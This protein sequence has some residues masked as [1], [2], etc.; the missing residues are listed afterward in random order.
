MPA[1]PGGE[2]LDELIMAMGPTRLEAKRAAVD[3]STAP[4]VDHALVRAYVFGELPRDEANRVKDLI[5]KYEIWE[6]AKRAPLREYGPTLARLLDEPIALCRA[7][8]AT[9]EE[10]AA[11][12][13]AHDAL[14]DEIKDEWGSPLH[15]TLDQSTAPLIDFDFVRAASSPNVADAAR[16]RLAVLS[17]KFEAWE[18][19]SIAAA[20]E[21]ADP[22]SCGPIE[23]GAVRSFVR[24][25]L[26]EEDAKSIRMARELSEAWDLAIEAAELELAAHGR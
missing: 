8:A 6:D 16:E 3:Q 15:K 2:S 14:L 9:P 10:E 26:N 25:E 4:P 12:Q 22:P 11:A 19:A 5:E 13:A 20:I 1:N 18:R 23:W 17:M 7:A 21:M 24:N